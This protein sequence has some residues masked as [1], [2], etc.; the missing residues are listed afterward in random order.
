MRVLFYKNIH[1]T[2]VFYKFKIGGYKMKQYY[3][4][5]HED[6]NHYGMQYNLGLNEDVKPFNPNSEHGGGI[7]FYDKEDVLY[8]LRDEQGTKLAIIEVPE[9]EQVVKVGNRYKGFK[10]HR[11]II[12]EIQD[13]WVYENFP[14]PDTYCLDMT[15]LFIRACENGALEFVQKLLKHY[16]INI[17]RDNDYA[18]QTACENGYLEI[19]KWLHKLGGIDNHVRNDYPFHLACI[20]GH[21][22]TAKWLY[23]L[24]GVDIHAYNDFTFCSVCKEGHLEVA[25]WLHDLGGVNINARGDEAFRLAYSNGHLE[26]CK[27]LKT[28]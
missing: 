11:I 17:H 4:I 6:M 7:L 3:K 18:F 14:W 21:L 5:L 9:G 23:K 15:N 16:K 24:G 27:W 20:N 8:Y 22:E 25:K 19:A 10:A 12:K 13:L 28:L 1:I 26:L 2:H